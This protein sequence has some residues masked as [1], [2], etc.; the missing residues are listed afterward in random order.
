MKQRVIEANEVALIH[1]T[2]AVRSLS[3]CL[4]LVRMPDPT[5]KKPDDWDEDAPA[6]IPDPQSKKPD[7]WLDNE[8]M[9]IPDPNAVKPADWKDEEDGPWEAPLIGT[10]TCGRDSLV[11]HGVACSSRHS[12]IEHM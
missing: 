9:Q 12:Y 5:A 10:P 4:L 2:I 7:G 8:S 3:Y 11:W 6:T 1:C